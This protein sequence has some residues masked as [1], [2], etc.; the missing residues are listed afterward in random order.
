MLKNKLKRAISMIISTA[1][2]MTAAVP[3]MT[4]AATPTMEGHGLT[5]AWYKAK[6]GSDR[7]DI[8]R[9]EF[10]ESNYLGNQKTGNLNGESFKS[11]IADLIGSSDD[12]QFVLARFTGEIEISKEEAYTFYMTGDDGFRLYIDNELVID[13]WR[14]EWEKEQKSEPVILTEGRHDIRV[15]YLQGWGGAWVRLDWESASITKETVPESVLYLPEESYYEDEV[16]ALAAE[17][18][19]AQA[20]CE[21]YADYESVGDLKA[22]VEAAISVKDAD[23]SEMEISDVIELLNKA[24]EDLIAAKTVFYIGMGVQPSETYTE[25]YNPLYQGQD[26]FVT[27]KNGFYYLVSSSNDDSEC[28]IYVSKSRTLTDQ[29]EKMLVMD[30][31]GKQRRIFAPEL[32]WL[33]DDEGGHWYIYYCADI[34]NYERDYPEIA[35]RYELGSEHH[36]ACA[37]R[38]KTDDPMG[39]YED[40]GPLYCGEN[41]V[42]LGAN[43]IT[44]ME[45]DGS[46]FLIWGTLGPNQPLGPAIVEMD[47]PG[48]V[49]KDRNMLPIGGGE[50]PRVLKNADGD[51]FVTMSEGGYTTD[52]Y[53]LSVLCFT[54]D[55]KE[56]LLDESKWYAKRDVFTSTS[57]VSGPARASFVKSADGTEDWMIYHSRVYKEVDNNWWRQVN[58]KKFG[59]NEDGTPD[60]GTP[61]S[62]NKVNALPSGDPGQGDMYQAEASILEGGAIVQSDNSNYSGEGYVHIPNTTGAAANFIVNAD[63]AGDY[64]VGLRYAYGVQ[65]GGEST[66]NPTNQLPG[67]ASMN[68]YVN[69]EKADTIQM[70]KTS[71]TWNEWFTGSKRLALN[72]GENLI[73]YT[74]ES[75]NVGNVNLDYLTMYEA[76]V[77]YTDA[78]IRPQS[79]VL[80][81][82]YTVLAAGET[83]QIQANVQPENAFERGVVYSCDN[84][85]VATVDEGG[86]VTGI[87][88]GKAV[89]TVKSAVDSKVKAEYI[90]IVARTETVESAKPAYVELSNKQIVLTPGKTTDLQPKVYPAYAKDTSLTFTSDNA[91]V[92]SVN[93]K[94]VVTAKAAGAAVITAVANGDKSVKQVCTIT[95]NPNKVKQVKAAR[96]KKSKKV[97]IT[98]KKSDSADGYI[99]YRAT[100]KKGTYKA[101]KT[102]KKVTKTSHVDKK[103]KKNKTYYYKVQAYKNAGGQ[104][105]TGS[106]SAAKKAKKVKLKRDID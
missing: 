11:L 38:S 7:N 25:F 103:A 53:R 63:K 86:K 36:V 17:I 2:L 14:Q 45:Y 106:L 42:I 104:K 8:T 91:E 96:V 71:I 48:T 27:Q 95:V 49:T 35:E 100:T 18:D 69:G 87:T 89:I 94:G 105:L 66:N 31:Q 10:A 97:K 55:S 46:L 13:F 70:D 37:L 34:L 28:K 77:P 16:R 20:V 44:L 52:G 93:E 90:V 78:E 21:A 47:T 50:G 76:D 22:A 1:M 57:A 84:E 99:I 39:E 92:A 41:G 80:D 65:K 67:R 12:S 74:V 72:E 19:K 101:I 54:G 98:W 29:G 60:F 5:G 88:E 9:F 15:E 26:P 3:Q 64:I 81:K 85:A 83:A 62:T 75:G 33:N 4:A 79:I 56:Q 6:E 32:F 58:I 102:V 51:L 40:L 82:A 59:W 30:M 68:I 23:Y 61:V 73:T 43:D 24:S